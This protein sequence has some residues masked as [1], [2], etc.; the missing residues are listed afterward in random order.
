MPSTQTGIM[1][2]A[3]A[4]LRE[5]YRLKSLHKKPSD[6]NMFQ[7]TRKCLC[8]TQKQMADILNVS[9]ASL[10]AYEYGSRNP[11]EDAWKRLSDVTHMSVAD[12]LELENKN[13]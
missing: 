11:G 13:R 8:V 1:E 5:R 12:L 3:D 7:W 10:K 6:L 4:Y 2:L 9:V